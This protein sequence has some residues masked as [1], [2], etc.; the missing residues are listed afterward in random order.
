MKEEKITQMLEKLEV[1]KVVSDGTL[2]HVVKESR[3]QM[4]G[5][6]LCHDKMLIEYME[7]TEGIGKS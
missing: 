1:K 4:S 6:T 3:Q 7:N 5:P 2:R